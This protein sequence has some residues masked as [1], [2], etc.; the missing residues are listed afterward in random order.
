M[1]PDPLCKDVFRRRKLIR[2]TA[3]KSAYFP[4]RYLPGI[5]RAACHA[6]YL[7]ML[8]TCPLLAIM[9]SAQNVFVTVDDPRPDHVHPPGQPFTIDV[10]ISDHG[11]P[12]ADVIAQWLDERPAEADRY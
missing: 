8:I 10:S 9:A 1:L 3:L 5:R 6:R 4:P 2:C 12:D 11:V 7:C